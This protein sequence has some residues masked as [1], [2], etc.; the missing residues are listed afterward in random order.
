LSVGLV[1]V[2]LAV[3]IIVKTTGNNS[4]PP[5]SG[6]SGVATG[7]HPAAANPA[8]VKIV[9]SIPTSVFDSVGTDGLPAAFTV[10]AKQP[11]LTSDK[12][13]QFVYVGAEFCPYCAMM[14][15][16]LVI[17]LSR[18]GTFSGLKQTSSADDDADIPTFS[19]LGS[20]YKSPYLVFSPY[21][22]EDRNSQPLESVPNS[23][24]DLYTTYDGSNSGSASKFDQAAGIPFLDIANKYVSAGTAANWKT[25]ILPALTNGGPGSLSI[26]QGLAKPT[27]ALGT[28]FSAKLLIAQANYITAAICDVDGHAPASV[29][30]SS[31]VM[32]AAK[33][34]AAAPTVS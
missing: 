23:V 30:N 13:P 29:C 22:D 6:S 16:P 26:A 12:L 17:A 15:W 34:L 9:T 19:F 32:A 4:T 21:E 24:N 5:S 18:F 3:L 25:G 20:S 27:G 10:T 33:V 2:I 1:V 8:V 28:A 7:Q 11:S 14:R 31:G